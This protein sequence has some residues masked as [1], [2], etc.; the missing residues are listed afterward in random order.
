MMDISE[1]LKKAWQL[2][3]ETGTI[4]SK[5]YAMIMVQL[6][7][8]KALENMKPS[9]PDS[10]INQAIELFEYALFKYSNGKDD[11]LTIDKT[12]DDRL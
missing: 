4:T 2:T 3:K 10:S 8:M 9:A 6:A 11:N 12:S 5:E 1:K 7:T